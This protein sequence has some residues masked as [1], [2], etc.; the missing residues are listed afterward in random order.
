MPSPPGRPLPATSAA[1]CHLRARVGARSRRYGGCTA[2][3]GA[4]PGA[5]A[6]AYCVRPAGPPPQT[7]RLEVLSSR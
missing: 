2:A 3:V 7:G 5:P 6:S 1:A 4:P